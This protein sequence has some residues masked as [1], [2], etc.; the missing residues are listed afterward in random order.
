MAGFLSLFQKKKEITSCSAVVVAA[1]NARRME[2]I[3]KIMTPLGELPVLVHTLYA[4]QDCPAIDEIVVVTRIDLLVQISRMCRELPLDKVR[5]IVVGGAERI[6]S[7]QAGLREVRPEAN[8][9]AIHDGARPL[10][11]QEILT[12]TIARAAETGAAAPAIPVTDTIKRAKD[13]R[14]VDTVDRSDLW[15]MQTPQVFEAGLIRAA[16]EKALADGQLLT[17][18]CAAV[19]RLGMPVTLTQG[20]KENIKITTPFDLVLGEAV[21]EARVKGVL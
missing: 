4:L 13:G 11:T 18:D 6:H 12:Q 2:G 15:A 10:V 3:D 5:K 20:S 8:L 1:G 14:S 17:D 16:T 7:V 21:L 19:E 9:I